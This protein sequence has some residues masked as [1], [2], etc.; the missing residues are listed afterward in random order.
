MRYISLAAAIAESKTNP[1]IDR[2]LSLRHF[3]VERDQN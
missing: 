3:C 2:G 1:K